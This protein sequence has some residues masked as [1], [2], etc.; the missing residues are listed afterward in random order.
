[1]DQKKR[2][3]RGLFSRIFGRFDPSRNEMAGVYGPPQL[4]GLSPDPEEP[5]D[6]D[7]PDREQEDFTPAKNENQKVYG[8]PEHFG[9][10]R[11]PLQKPRDED[12]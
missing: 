3:R 10:P 9:R 5:E 7:A 11:P 4:L 12:E 6:I 1:M 8:P 2:R